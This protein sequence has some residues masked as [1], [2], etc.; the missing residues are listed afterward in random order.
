LLTLLIRSVLQAYV[1][2]S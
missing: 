1:R 2:I